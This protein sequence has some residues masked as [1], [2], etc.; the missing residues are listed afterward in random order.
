MDI[1]YGY[2]IEFECIQ[3]TPVIT[4]LGVHQSRRAD[5]SVPDFLLASSLVD[6]S[7][8]VPQG[9]YLDQFSNTCLRLI[10]PPGGLA[11]SASGVITDTGEPDAPLPE[12]RATPPEDLPEQTLVYLLGSRYCETDRLGN[13]AWRVFGTRGIGAATVRE[14][15]TY[16]H[17][18]IRFDYASARN[19]RT[20][21]ETLAERV[22][23]CRDFAHL[24]ITLCR[25][26]NIPARYCTGYLGDIG[27]PIDPNPGD[28]S[29][30]F[31]VFLDGRWWTVDARHNKP[32][33]G[34][35]LM[36][37]GRDAMDVPILH[38]F[39][40]HRLRRF[41]VLTEEVFQPAAVAG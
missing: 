19:T 37:Q 28:F 26:L 8:V 5:L 4:M 31:E 23:V 22:G 12:V 38:S 24:A 13:M 3:R 34:R 39:G 33:I 1:R 29:A 9:L 2:A 20:A 17:D 15:C 30:W 10:A 27:V 35:I 11:L 7:P 6:G 14:I 40:A 21:A 41:D 18:H 25:C 16:V 36:A 32:R